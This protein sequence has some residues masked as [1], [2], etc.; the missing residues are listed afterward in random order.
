MQPDG[1]Y[2]VHANG[3]RV[4]SAGTAQAMNQLVPGVAGP[5]AKQITIGRNAPDGWTAFHGQIGDVFLYKTALSETE[6][7]QLEA[8]IAK[9][10]EGEN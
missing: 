8:F 7:R 2:E 4:L 10:L 1:S 5:F 6:R 3:A 9:G